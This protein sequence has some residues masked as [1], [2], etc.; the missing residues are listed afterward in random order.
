MIS[1]VNNNMSDEN[2]IGNENVKIFPK[3]LQPPPTSMYH[4]PPCIT[5]PLSSYV[6]L[7]HTP[8]TGG[9]RAVYTL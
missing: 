9:E 2:L 7:Y 4:T 3:I 6:L 8:C 1:N 5:G